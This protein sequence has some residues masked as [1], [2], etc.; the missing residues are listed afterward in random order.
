MTLA[1]GLS[2]LDSPSNPPHRRGIKPAPAP[3]AK[4]DHNRRLLLN[5]S[6]VSRD[7]A[8]HFAS[9]FKEALMIPV[10]DGHVQPVHDVG[11]F[12]KYLRTELDA[13]CKDGRADEAEREVERRSQQEA[14]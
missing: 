13:C 5:R 12:V 6:W 11:I 2:I 9:I 14:A 7:E 1:L 8:M 3:A 4:M 10:H